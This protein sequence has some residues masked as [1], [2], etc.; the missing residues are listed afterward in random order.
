MQSSNFS[1]LFTVCSSRLTLVK[2]QII[3]LS[4]FASSAY[5]LNLHPNLT[6]IQPK[7]VSMAK[8]LSS[9]DVGS[10]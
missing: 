1:F 6:Q 7:Y 3:Y 4:L 8:I 9:P 10:L 2:G 5:L